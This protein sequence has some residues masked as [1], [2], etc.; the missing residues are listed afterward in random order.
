MNTL[1]PSS[2][3]FLN[4]GPAFWLGMTFATTAAIAGLALSKAIESEAVLFTLLII[5]GATMV[6]LGLALL[7][8]NANGSGECVNKGEAQRR[9]IKR[10]AVFTALYLTTFAALSFMDGMENVP[11]I[12]R[13]IIA[14]MPGFAIVGFFWAIGRLIIEEKD[15]FMRMLTIRQIL[16]SSALALSAA[17]VWGFLESADLVMHLDGY[18]YAVIWFGGLF[19]GALANR[20]EYG[21]WGAA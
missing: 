13:L 14:A 17:S 11:R 12:V 20:I 16:I 3:G 7:N 5:P 8:A 1:T 19:I 2:S 10:V 4:R 21:S 6:A 18:W 15:E 9:Y